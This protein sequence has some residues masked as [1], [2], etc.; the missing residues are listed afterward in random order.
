MLHNVKTAIVLGAG[1]SRSVSYAASVGLP[2]PLDAD[3]FELLKQ[4]RDTNDFPNKDLS[5][6]N[7]VLKWRDSLPEDSRDS[8]ERAFYTLQTSAYLLE[9]FTSKSKTKPTDD[10]VVAAFATSI[11]AL[12]RKAHGTR[13]CEYHKCL[14]AKLGGFDTIISFNYDLVAERALKDRAEQDDLDFGPWLYCLGSRPPNVSNFPTLLKL[15]GSSNWRLVGDQKS[16]RISVNT[17][18]WA[19]LDRHPGYRGY[20]G[21]GTRFPI[22]LPFWDKRIEKGPW[23]ALWRAAYQRLKEVSQVIVWGYSLPT[24]DIKVRQLFRLAIGDLCFCLCVIDPSWHAR[25]RW[26]V[27]FP[28]AKFFGHR[29]IL[30]RGLLPPAGGIKNILG[31]RKQITNP[32]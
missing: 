2:S 31:N 17:T 14:F 30:A 3:F 1:A 23:L 10:Q 7:E 18:E 25:K 13:T 20:H 27:L 16:E 22:F 19:Q 8:F 21:T 15:H 6:I 24:T 29:T 32:H 26:R 4:L 28:K 5:K 9:N 11:D 12:L